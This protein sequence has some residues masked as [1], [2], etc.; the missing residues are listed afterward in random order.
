MRGA[1]RRVTS[2]YAIAYEPRAGTC[3]ISD[4][5]GNNPAMIETVAAMMEV[6]NLSRILQN[7]ICHI[8]VGMRLYSGGLCFFLV[9]PEID[10][11]LLVNW[12]KFSSGFDIGLLSPITLQV[13]MMTPLVPYYS[14]LARATI[15]GIGVGWRYGCALRC[16]TVR[17]YDIF[18]FEFTLHLHCVTAP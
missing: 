14:C 6:K 8:S 12:N 9:K 2:R 7:S 4:V 1:L 10:F 17:V 18:A 15:S 16:V 5:D 13:P 3:H 11:D